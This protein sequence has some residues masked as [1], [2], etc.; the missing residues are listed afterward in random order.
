MQRLTGKDT[1]AK[2]IFAVAEVRFQRS[3]DS[4][5]KEVILQRMGF[6]LKKQMDRV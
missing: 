6:A 4:K 1:T 5:N 2:N 3:A